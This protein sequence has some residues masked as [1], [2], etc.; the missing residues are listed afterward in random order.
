MSINPFDD[1]NG[2]FSSWS[3]TRSSLWPTLADVSA[4]W[5]VVTSETDH[6]VYP[7]YIE[8]NWSDIRPSTSAREAGSGL[9]FHT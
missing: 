7:D 5:E 6:A 2:S 1:D 9:V 3:T 4:G 8:E